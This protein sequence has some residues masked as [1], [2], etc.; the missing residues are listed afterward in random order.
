MT[1]SRRVPLLVLAASLSFT[2]LASLAAPAYAQSDADKATA[3]MLGQEGQT[4]LDAKDYKTAED[5]FRRAE[6]LYH[7]P[8][9]ALGLARALAANGKV[10]AAQE[11][12]NRIIRE[13]VAP[14]APAV[15]VKAVEDAKTEVSAVSPR[16][17]GV[18]I[19]VAG[20]DSP[21]VTLDDT[22]VPSAAL[23]VRRPVDPG[24]HV[25][26]VSADG[27]ENAEQ[28]FNVVEG[29]S[30]TVPITLKKAAAAPIA[31][32]PAT[33][34]PTTTT[35]PA[36]DTTASAD[37]GVASHSSQ[38]TIG[39]VV[40]GVGAAG[41]VTGAVTGFLALGKHS[42]LENSCPNNTC[43]SAQQSDIDS[44]HTMGT[45]STIGFI[46]GLVGVGAGTVLILTAP[47][48]TTAQGPSVTPYVGLGTLGAVGRF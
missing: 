23:G 28:K 19:T 25:V 16:I 11:T 44:F 43:T 39:W 12:Y 38:K 41:L 33:A 30:A 42:D 8:T 7:A 20:P 22:Q 3:R 29:G 5:R 9:L 24:A 40:L 27:W 45:I 10:V 13:G 18:T 32:V 36:T 4:A 14:G 17:A 21:K 37:T 2:S 1:L 47:K 34:Q 48:T 31:A 46:A 15:F 26:R 35:A 6:S